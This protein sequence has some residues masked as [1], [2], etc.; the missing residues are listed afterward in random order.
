MISFNINSSVKVKLTKHGK[1]VYREWFEKL[2]LP[3]KQQFQLPTED[4]E[5]YST[6]QMWHLMRVFGNE[7][8]MEC[9]LCFNTVIRIFVYTAE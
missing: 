3:V 8:G 6:W 7:M 5:G 1:E 4:E 9:E 2:D